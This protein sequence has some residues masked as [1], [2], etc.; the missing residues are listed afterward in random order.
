MTDIEAVGAESECD[1]ALADA[2]ERLMRH[3]LYGQVDS[4]PRIR[5]FMEHH[6]FAVWDFMSLL[7]RLQQVVTGLEL[8][9]LPPRDPELARLINEIVLGE[10]SDEDGRG[11]FTTHFDLYR[12]AMLECGANTAL[13]DRFLERI[14]QRVPPGQALRDLPIAPSTA[15]FVRGNLQ[16]ATQGAAHEVAAAFCLGREDIIPEM[17]QRLAPALQAQGHCVNRLSY[18]LQRHIEVDGDRHG[19]MSQRLLTRLIEDRPER[20]QAARRAALQAITARIELW[21]GVLAALPAA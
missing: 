8:P 4:L 21:D 6:V 17:F 15:A 10:E 2:R 7:K 19:P 13:I 11:G 3:A 12:E 18:Y 9:W 20:R 5:V 16:L 1:A 14:A